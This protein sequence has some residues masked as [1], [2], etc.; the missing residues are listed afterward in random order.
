MN[1]LS[2]GIGRS[3]W[4]KWRRTSRSLGGAFPGSAEP[5]LHDLSGLIGSV[6]D[7]G[8]LGGLPVKERPVLLVLFVAPLR[9]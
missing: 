7:R 4:G 8:R 2:L 1:G 3:C 5:S 9:L 6:N